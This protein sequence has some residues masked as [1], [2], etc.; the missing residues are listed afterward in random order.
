MKDLSFGFK[1]VD[2][3]AVQDM[4]QMI[5]EMMWLVQATVVYDESGLGFKEKIR[6]VFDDVHALSSDCKTGNWK[7]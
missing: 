5:K 6:R 1:P 4:M 2:L 7:V 3:K